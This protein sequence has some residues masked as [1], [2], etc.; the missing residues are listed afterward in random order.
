MEAIRGLICVDLAALVIEVGGF[1][2]QTT[3]KESLTSPQ[4]RL[5]VTI[6]SLCEDRC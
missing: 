1:S 6:S 2:D 4:L 5:Q 3:A